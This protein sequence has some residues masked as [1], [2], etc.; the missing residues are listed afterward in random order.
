[1]AGFTG[2]EARLLSLVDR[3]LFFV[4]MKRQSEP[5]WATFLVF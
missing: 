5:L 4:E 2:H 1:M 3:C